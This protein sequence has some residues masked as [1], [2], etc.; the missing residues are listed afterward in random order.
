MPLQ[1]EIAEPLHQIVEN[2]KW[3]Y[4]E[5][6][7]SPPS[8]KQGSESRPYKDPVRAAPAKHA[9]VLRILPGNQHTEML[10]QPD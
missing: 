8:A 3:S 9:F 4:E 10:E 6:H 7:D 1:R 5:G 2:N